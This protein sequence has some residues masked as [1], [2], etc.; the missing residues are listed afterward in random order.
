MYR[1]CTQKLRWLDMWFID[2]YPSAASE[3][4]PEEACEPARNEQ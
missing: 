2:I 3:P 4:N 1:K